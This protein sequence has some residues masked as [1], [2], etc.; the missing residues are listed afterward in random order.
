MELNEYLAVRRAYNRVR[1]LLLTEDRITFDEYAL[2]IHLEAAS[3]P[4]RTSEI[5][6]YQQCLRP[7]MT[8][9]T[10]HL[11][12]LGFLDRQS[13]ERDR[14]NIICTISEKGAAEVANLTKAVIAQLTVDPIYEETMTKKRL[15][16]MVDAMGTC[17]TTAR[18]LIILC[19]YAFN[20]KSLSVTDI[21]NR[22]GLLQPTV[23][24]A[25]NTLIEGGFIE[26]VAT[27]ASHRIRM[28]LSDLG[29]AYAE[30]IK[31]DI[32][33]IRIHYRA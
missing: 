19:L 16:H 13:G 8:H 5:A 30:E 29:R 6:T 24:M 12:E 27:P 25:A 23:S 26:K 33:D 11:S 1:Q 18:D 32:E 7:T 20:E 4:V 22:T 28:H 10:H 14:R 9:R 15:K 17:G 21:V 2:L 31:V 3:R